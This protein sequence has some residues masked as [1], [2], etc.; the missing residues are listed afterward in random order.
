MIVTVGSAVVP[1]SRRCGYMPL[2]AAIRM[3]DGRDLHAPCETCGHQTPLA[4]PPRRPEGAPVVDVVADPSALRIAAATVRMLV[5]V[6]DQRRPPHQLRE[7]A[8][9]RVLRYLHALPSD[10]L[11]SRGGAFLAARKADAPSGRIKITSRGIN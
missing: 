11:G 2:G 9:P 6:L 3:G 8:H 5:D 10:A 4:A 7:L 1:Q